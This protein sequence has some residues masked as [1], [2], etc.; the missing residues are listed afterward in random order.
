MKNFI[1]HLHLKK[2][3]IITMKLLIL[4]INQ[5]GTVMNVIKVLIQIEKILYVVPVLFMMMI[6]LRIEK[7]KLFSYLIFISLFLS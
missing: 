2:I 6:V 5:K 4:I 7:Y 3:I 1:H